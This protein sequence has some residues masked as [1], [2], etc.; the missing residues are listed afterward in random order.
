MER[1][2]KNVRISFLSVIHITYGTLNKLAITIKAKTEDK[3]KTE[4]EFTSGSESEHE[5]KYE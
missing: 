4:Y 2:Y 1:D 3:G 5:Y